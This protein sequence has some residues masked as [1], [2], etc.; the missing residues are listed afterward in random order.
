MDHTGLGLARSIPALTIVGY[1]V[2][3]VRNLLYRRPEIY[4]L[5]YPEPNDETPMMCRRMF[6]RYLPGPPR[7]ILD[8]GCGT[9]RDI[10]SLACK[11]ADCVGVDIS[12]EMIR[13][14]KSHRPQIRFEVGDMRNFRLN[15]SFDTILSMGSAFMYATTNADVEAVLDTFAAHA[16]DGSLLILDINNSASYLPDGSFRQTSEFVVN[17]PEFTAKAKTDYSFNRRR[18]IL[19][20]RRTW[21][22]H[23]EPPVDDYC[24]YRMFF[25]VELE[26]LLA[27]RHFKIVGM[28]DNMQLEESDLT[29]PRLYVASLFQA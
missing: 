3:N 5:V 25:P 26:Y 27:T 18:Q 6:E 10:N 20:R 8:I 29:G 16:H 23:G 4:E 15:R 24:E 9:G 21:Q 28:F 7:S 11:N 19:I 22:I 1:I 14:A 17:L 2:E 13:Y 12:S